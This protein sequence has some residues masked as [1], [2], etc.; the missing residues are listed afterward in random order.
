MR[1]AAIAAALAFLCAA[2]SSEEKAKAPEAEAPAALP[3]GRPAI[4]EAAREGPEPFVRALYAVYVAGGPKEPPPPPGQDPIYSRMLNAA[5]ITDFNLSKG[6]VPTLNH[7]PI[8]NC[9]D[10]GVFTLDS[11]T[12]ISTGERSADAAVAFTNAGQT[13]RQTLKV[14][15][16]GV[17]WK[18]E[19]V[20]DADGGSLNDMLIKAIEARGG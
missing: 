19:D 9:Q 17:M 3:P 16:E 14:V 2:C 8:C 5:I 6:E 15:K 10:Q 1:R 4:Y 13:T 11:L 7:D 18:V 20:I 12:V